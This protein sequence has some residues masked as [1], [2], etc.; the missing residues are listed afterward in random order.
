MNYKDAFAID[1]KSSL[2]QGNKD[3]K[4]NLKNYSNYEP[5]LVY[6]F[7][8]KYFIRL[9]LFETRILELHGFLQHHY[10]YCNDPELYYSVLDLEVVPKIEE[11]IDHAQ[12]RLE[13]RG[14][15]KEVKLE[16]GFTESEGIIQNYDLDYPLMFHQTSLSRKHKEFAKRVEIIN[17]FILDYKGKKEKRPLKWI[18]GPSQLAVIIQELILQ[19]Y[20]EGDMRNGDVNCRKLARELYDV[21]D[22]K[23]CDS[24]SSIEIYLSPGNKRHKGAKQKFDDRNF[25]IPPARLT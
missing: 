25:L 18:A 12:V 24:A 2:D 5:K 21:F 1:E 23:D 8:L 6:D 20:M 10:D 13:G 4:F 16:N 15:Y 7:Y 22:I 9:L 3:Y 11:I 19:G 14:Y 17:K